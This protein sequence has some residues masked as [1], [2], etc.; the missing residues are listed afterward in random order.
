MIDIIVQWATILSPVIAVGIAAW[1]SMK[2]SKD[3]Q[4]QIESIKALSRQTAEDALKQ[5]N[6]L[7]EISS[8]Q[9]D[10]M[11]ITIG[12]ELQSVS[13]RLDQVRTRSSSHNRTPP[14]MQHTDMYSHFQKQIDL[15]DEEE[16]L[17]Q[18]QKR[19]TAIYDQLVDTKKRMEKNK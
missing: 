19:L 14:I 10:S 18:Q 4:R 6:S 12:N 8:V 1:T 2:S 16:F 5:I 7:K 15:K 3:T 9:L 11:I 17:I 13:L